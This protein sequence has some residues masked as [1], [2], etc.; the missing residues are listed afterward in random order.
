VVRAGRD[1]AV[2][3]RSKPRGEY[4]G[5]DKCRV[6]WDGLVATVEH[7]EGGPRCCCRMQVSAANA[8]AEAA[9]AAL[10]AADREFARRHGR[11]EVTT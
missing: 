11:S 8:T 9:I 6:T 7:F 2:E 5:E 10:W 4:D 1:V 3:R